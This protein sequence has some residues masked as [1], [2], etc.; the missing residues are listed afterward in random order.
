MSN[1]SKKGDPSS[2][3]KST[4]TLNSA[5]AHTQPLPPHPSLSSFNP[6]KTHF[7]AIVS[8]GIAGGQRLR[9]WDVGRSSIVKEWDLPLDVKEGKRGAR[10]VFWAR[11]A[12]GGSSATTSGEVD[13]EEDGS[14]KKKRKRK[15]ASGQAGSGSNEEEVDCVVVV[16]AASLLYYTTGQTGAKPAKV[17]NLST[18]PSTA[19]ALTRGTEHHILTVSYTT[20][21]IVDPVTGS[22]QLSTPLP[23]GFTPAS[24]STS[25][26]SSTPIAISVLDDS[27]EHVNIAIASTNLTVLTL[28]LPLSASLSSKEKVQWTRPQSISIEPIRT[29]VALPLGGVRFVTVEEESRVGTVWSATP[30]GSGEQNIETIATIPSPTSEPIH[31]ISVSINSESDEMEMYATSMSGEISIY[32]LDA[33]SFTATQ[34]T[35]STNAN[36]NSLSSSKKKRGKKSAPV[37]ALKPVSKVSVV[38]PSQGNEDVGMRIL[39]CVSAGESSQ[40]QKTDGG[41]DVDEEVQEEIVV[42]WMGGV[43]RVRW[44]KIVSSRLL[45]ILNRELIR[46]GAYGFVMIAIPGSWRWDHSG[47]GHQAKWAGIGRQRVCRGRK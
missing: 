41:M 2:R 15:S 8:A 20:F 4:S 11:M 7:A 38:I 5:P 35:E 3:A 18:T 37:P 23:D 13:G 9:C 1:K 17:V 19:I 21:E 34:D 26:S 25:T 43:G 47:S 29:I 27:A 46:Y 6:S 12:L 28:P 14:S 32:T 44:E 31:D 36:S 16:Q 10:A 30:N 24:V 45:S 42:G 33:S 22:V 39:A 40:K